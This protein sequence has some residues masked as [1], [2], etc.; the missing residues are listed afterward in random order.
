M[1]PI[2]VDFNDRVRRNSL[3]AQKRQ[4]ALEDEKHR[5]EERQQ[6]IEV[7]LDLG[8]RYDREW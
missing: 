2:H 4:R 1:A 8:A 5:V 7:Q 3:G 6:V